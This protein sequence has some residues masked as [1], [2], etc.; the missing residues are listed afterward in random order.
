MK[1]AFWIIVGAAAIL[2][3]AWIVLVP[4][5]RR[6]AYQRGYLNARG[7]TPRERTIVE[8]PVFFSRHYLQGHHDQCNNCP[9]S[10]PIPQPNNP[11]PST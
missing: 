11:P 8:V 4:H 10:V 7:K 6:N 9:P 3:V 5:L 2:V 1:K